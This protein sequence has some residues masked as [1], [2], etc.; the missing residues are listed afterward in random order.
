M[1]RSEIKD[2]KKFGIT[3]MG[4]ES[5]IAKEI[6][7]FF[8]FVKKLKIHIF[9]NVKCYIKILLIILVYHEKS[10]VLNKS[11]KNLEAI[12]NIIILLLL[13][14]SFAVS[15]YN[16]SIFYLSIHKIGSFSS[17][18]EIL[19]S[20]T[21]NFDIMYVYIWKYLRISRMALYINT[22]L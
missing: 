19:F 3:S 9:D 6:K 4:D 5:N 17:S 20:Y 11:N 1:I 8:L 16:W 13:V 21:V 2:K 12:K 7:R 15:R 14:S 22:D 18:T 10:Y